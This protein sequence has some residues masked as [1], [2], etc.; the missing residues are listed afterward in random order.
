MKSHRIITTVL[1][2]LALAVTAVQVQAAPVQLGFVCITNNSLI[3]AAI[4][5]AQLSVEV[6]ETS[7]GVAAFTFTNIGPNPCT[8]AQLYFD[9]DGLLSFDS[10]INGPS[11]LFQ[12]GATP[13]DLPGGNSI[14]PQFQTTPGLLAGA[15]PPPAFNGVDPGEYVKIICLLQPGKTWADVL[16]DFA[17]GDLRI[18]LHVISFADGGSES[19]ITP[20]PAT[21]ALLGLGFLSIRYARRR[22]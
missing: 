2:V 10:V 6:E 17:S 15:L 12:Q 7:P 5:E 19:F 11:V 8:I 20:E 9:D 14:S 4:G 18:G 16:G 1:A 21:L 22:P 13:G 3:D